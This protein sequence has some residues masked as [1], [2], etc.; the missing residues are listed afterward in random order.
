MNANISSR[1]ALLAATATL[2]PLCA[3]AS[4][5]REAPSIAGQPRVDGTDFYMFR[6]YEPGRS[7]YVTLIANYIPLQD[8]FGGLCRAAARSCVTHYSHTFLTT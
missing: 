3:V 8:P 2:L 6:S 5:H 7:A 4:S 1:F